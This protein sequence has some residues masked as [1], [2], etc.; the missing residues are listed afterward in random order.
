M[1]QRVLSDL[2]GKHLSVAESLSEVLASEHP[3]SVVSSASMELWLLPLV[4][5][6][7]SATICCLIPRG[8]RSALGFGFSFIILEIPDP[9]AYSYSAIALDMLSVGDYLCETWP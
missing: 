8:G 6:P 9:A 4:L 7:E 1:R 2:L 3:K 5:Q